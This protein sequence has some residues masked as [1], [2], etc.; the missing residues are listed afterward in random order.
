MWERTP[1]QDAAWLKRTY[2]LWFLFACS[3]RHQHPPTHIHTHPHRPTKPTTHTDPLHSLFSPFP[4]PSHVLR[5]APPAS[6]SHALSPRPPPLRTHAC[7]SPSSSIPH[8]LS[9]PRPAPVT[10]VRT[11]Q[12][13]WQDDKFSASKAHK[14]RVR[15]VRRTCYIV[16]AILWTIATA[17]GASEWT[18]Y[19]HACRPSRPSYVGDVLARNCGHCWGKHLVAN[20]LYHFLLFTILYPVFLRN[21]CEN[22]PRYV[23]H[24]FR[25][26][27][28]V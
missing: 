24:A 15:Y 14:T 18:I 2:V 9:L 12:E 27:P 11:E 1:Y 6:P 26:G 17:T 7:P 20:S 16:H 5:S 13:T 21:M 25:L 22:F 23:N 19:V 8:R 4:V 3:W 10:Y 28:E